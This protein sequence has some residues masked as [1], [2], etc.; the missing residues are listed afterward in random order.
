[1]ENKNYLERVLEKID[2]LSDKEFVKLLDELIQE[3]DLRV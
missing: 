1:M 2:N 3:N